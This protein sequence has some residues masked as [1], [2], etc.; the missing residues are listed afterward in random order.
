VTERGSSTEGNSSRSVG[1]RHRNDPERILEVFR[2]SHL[3]GYPD[4]GAAPNPEGPDVFQPSLYVR[5]GT[6]NSVTITVHR[7]EMGQGVR[8]ALPMILAEELDAIGRAFGRSKPTRILPT[9]IS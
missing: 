3:D 8:T 4:P 2:R 9:A 7:S 6:D 5:I 1:R